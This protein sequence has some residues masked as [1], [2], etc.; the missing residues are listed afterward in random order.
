MSHTPEP[1]RYQDDADAYTHIIRQESDTRLILC[2]GPQSSKPNVKNNMIRIVA[3]VNSCAGMEDPAAEI[4][5]LRADAERYRWLRDSKHNTPAILALLDGI[6]NIIG[7]H[8]EF[9]A[10]IDSARNATK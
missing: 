10:A 1:W 4:A 5:S 7:S 2:Y 3:C 6:P 8:N 9:D